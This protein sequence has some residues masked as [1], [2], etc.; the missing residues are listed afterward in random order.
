MFL[1]IS[2]CWFAMCFASSITTSIATS[3]PSSS[4]FRHKSISFSS[5]VMALCSIPSGFSTAKFCAGCPRVVLMPVMHAEL[6]AF[7]VQEL[8]VN[9]RPNERAIFPGPISSQ[10]NIF[11]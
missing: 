4:V 6:A 2:C 5:A 3:I 7:F 1:L 10:L 11:N 9:H 8:D